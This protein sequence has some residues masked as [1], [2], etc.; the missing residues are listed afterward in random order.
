MLSPLCCNSR[1]CYS[2]IYLQDKQKTNQTNPNYELQST[3]HNSVPVYC[4]QSP[5]CFPMYLLLHLLNTTR[6]NYMVLLVQTN[7][8]SDNTQRWWRNS[9]VLPALK[10]GQEED[11]VSSDCSSSDN[12]NELRNTMIFPNPP[13]IS[14]C[15]A[16]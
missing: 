10:G 2:A 5:L 12:L 13:V 8:C 9:P 6:V 14:D 7:P 16:T 1:T 15:T 3:Q 4:F 11:K